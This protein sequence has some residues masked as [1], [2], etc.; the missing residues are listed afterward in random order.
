MCRERELHQSYNQ[1]PVES[2]LPKVVAATHDDSVQR[3]TIHAMIVAIVIVVALI[4]R[5]S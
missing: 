3:F 1:I 2:E 5:L 4:P